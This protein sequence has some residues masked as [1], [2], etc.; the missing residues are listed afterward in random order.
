MLF[1]VVLN[2]QE[3]V[4]EV[5]DQSVRRGSWNLKFVRDFND[6]ESLMV[7]DL[8]KALRKHSIS[9]EKD[10]VIW[11]GVKGDCFAIKEAFEV[12]QPRSGCPFPEK[13]IWVP[14]VPIKTAFYEWEVM[15]GKVLTLDKLQRRGLKLLNRCYLCGCVEETIHHIQQHYCECSLGDHF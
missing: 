9:F 6:W 12:L 14:C 10:K 15:W 8:L 13:G 3:I 1:E 7:V 5:W 4:V 11:K 2:K